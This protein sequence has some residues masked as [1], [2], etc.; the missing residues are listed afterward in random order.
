MN[1]ALADYSPRTA[2]IA[3]RNRK[4]RQKR[5]MRCRAYLLL[6]KPGLRMP[7]GSRFTAGLELSAAG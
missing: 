6:Q 2:L 7:S 1:V 3:E 4:R 5:E